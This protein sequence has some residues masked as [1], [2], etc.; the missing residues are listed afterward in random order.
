VLDRMDCE[1]GGIGRGKGY[2]L[3]YLLVIIYKGF[4]GMVDRW[5]EGML[6]RGGWGKGLC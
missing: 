6:K 4:D 2:L 5:N 3:T 1:V